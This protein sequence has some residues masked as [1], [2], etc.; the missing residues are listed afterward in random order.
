VSADSY[1][2]HLANVAANAAVD[3][4]AT[5]VVAIDVSAVL[6][7]TDVF[8]VCSGANPRHTAAIVDEVERKV[9]QAG[10]PPARREGQRDAS[11]VLLDFTDIVVHVQLEQERENYGLERLWRDC[12]RLDLEFDP[13]PSSVVRLATGSGLGDSGVIKSV[14]DESTEG[15]L[16]EQGTS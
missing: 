11:W 8:V 4:K 3:K 12:P 13:E 7:I 14:E 10:G 9:R 6:V 1:S 15:S 5:D 16:Q 2:I